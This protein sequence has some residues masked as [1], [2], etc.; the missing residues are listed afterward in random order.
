MRRILRKAN[1]PPVSRDEIFS[2]ISHPICCASVA[3]LAHQVN[4][5]VAMVGI[6]AAQ[7][8]SFSAPLARRPPLSASQGRRRFFDT[9][10]TSS[11]IAQRSRMVEQDPRRN[12]RPILFENYVDGEMP[13]LPPAF[14]RSSSSNSNQTGAEI[15]TWRNDRGLPPHDAGGL[16]KVTFQSGNGDARPES[17][18]GPAHDV[19]P[20]TVVACVVH[21]S[22]VDAPPTE[23]QLKVD[24]DCAG[25][26]HLSPRSARGIDHLWTSR[27]G[28]AFI[29]DN[30]AFD[31]AAGKGM[32]ERK[33]MGLGVDDCK[34]ITGAKLIPGTCEHHTWMLI[35]NASTLLSYRRHDN[36]LRHGNMQPV[37]LPPPRP[38]STDYIC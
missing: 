21:D 22:K 3:D 28:G 17:V 19:L 37:A 11:N 34:H 36:R 5:P 30:R 35:S 16:V 29:I 25:P 13:H 24:D 2:P 20:D 7:R 14:V 33:S 6:P 4:M 38:Q 31:A 1:T 12:L 18:R 32:L 15:N 23:R 26:Q 10:V 8:R 9:R 27:V